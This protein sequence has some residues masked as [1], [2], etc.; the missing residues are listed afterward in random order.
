MSVL[1]SVLFVHKEK[2]GGWREETMGKEGR[3]EDS[4][5]EEKKGMVKERRKEKRK[6]G[7][8]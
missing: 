7:N 4:R 2:K 5:D 3:Q 6:E 8:R 1:T